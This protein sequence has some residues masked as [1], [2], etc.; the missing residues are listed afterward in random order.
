[1]QWFYQRLLQITQEF[2]VGLCQGGQSPQAI[3]GSKVVF[4]PAL[5]HE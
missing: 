4:V 2:V 5:F 1:M 3:A